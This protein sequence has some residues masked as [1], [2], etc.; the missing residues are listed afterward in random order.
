MCFIDFRADE[1]DHFIASAFDYG[2][3][4]FELEKQN[5]ALWAIGFAPWQ[6]ADPHTFDAV[7]AG[8][9]FFRVSF[10]SSPRVANIFWQNIG[11]SCESN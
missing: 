7:S 5:F 6:L 2:E 8:D 9:N 10:H 11:S 3:H 1:M 4:G